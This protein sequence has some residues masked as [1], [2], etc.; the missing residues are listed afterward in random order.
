MNKAYLL[1]GGNIGNREKS[2]F[3]AAAEI[4]KRLGFIIK[5]SSVYQTKAW[6]NSAQGDFLNQ[7]LI[8]ATKYSPQTVLTGLVHIEKLMGRVRNDENG[9]R[10]SL[11]LT[12]CFMKKAGIGAATCR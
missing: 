5:K 4:G 12:F 1:L 11:T 6:G 2:L 8:V 3:N 9:R 7:A 10:E